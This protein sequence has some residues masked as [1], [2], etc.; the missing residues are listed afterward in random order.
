MALRELINISGRIFDMFKLGNS[1]F[2]IEKGSF[3]AYFAD[4][5]MNRRMQCEPKN[6]LSWHI[7]IQMESGP[8]VTELKNDEEEEDY[9]EVSPY[10][11][12]NNGFSLDV[13][14]WKSVEGISKIWEE[15]YNEDEEEAGTLCVF[16][17]EDVT[18]GKIEF[19]KRKGSVFS[20]R[21]SGT[22]NVYWDEEY[23]ENVPFEFE[24]ELLFEGVY[25]GCDRLSNQKE[26]EDAM[27][28]FID[29]SEFE[30]VSKEHHK[31]SG[32]I[33][34]SWRYAPRDRE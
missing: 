23:G 5:K 18:S 21:W 33:S 13:R 34:Y 24:G 4:D 14:S 29:I 8:L 31:I 7:D 30:C 27:A 9:E 32:G 19:L 2:E 3:H 22:A 12:H 20:V 6:W 10:L 26:L 1:E 15:P 11:Y 17:H 25:A 16:G 28:E